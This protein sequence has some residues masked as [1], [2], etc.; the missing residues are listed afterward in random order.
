LWTLPVD[1]D[2]GRRFL[3]GLAAASHAAYAN[4]AA[5]TTILRRI[6]RSALGDSSLA[7]PL[8]F[9][10]GHETIQRERHGDDWLWVHRHGASSARPPGVLTHD[11]VLA[12]IGQ[13]VPIPGSMG[14]DSFIGVVRPG[15]G[16]TFH[17]VAHGAGRVLEKVRAAEVFDEGEIEDSVRR[18]GVRL[19][20]YGA[21]NIAGQAPAS[22]KNVKGVVE[23]MVALDLVRPVAR[24]R[25]I[26][27]LKG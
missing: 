5:I 2:L 11:P 24:V 6:V 12:E 18:Q 13:P 22:F 21:D 20:R 15:A 25:P 23:A 1:S 19:Y 3:C 17:S 8:L 27:V 4:R 16:Q 7:L 26:A 10:C 14:S 9:D